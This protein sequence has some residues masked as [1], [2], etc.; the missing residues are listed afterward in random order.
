MLTFAD[1]SGA[2]G[3]GTNAGMR[4]WSPMNAQISPAHSWTLY[5]LCFTFSAMVLAAGS[6]TISMTVPSTSIF[7]P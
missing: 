2:Q 3:G 6:E 5:A 7:Q 4:V 1:F